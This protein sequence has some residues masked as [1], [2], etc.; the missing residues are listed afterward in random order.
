MW[1]FL[2]TRLPNLFHLGDP[3]GMVPFQRQQLSV[4]SKDFGDRLF[5]LPATD[6]PRADRIDPVFRDSLD[7][8]FTLD[9]KCERPNGVA[10]SL[11]AMTGK[12]AA[13]AVSQSQGARKA[14]GRHLETGE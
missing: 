14:I 12:L 1:L 4:G 13:A 3:M 10:L 11:G 9:H 8:L 6:N 7:V 5:E 2:R